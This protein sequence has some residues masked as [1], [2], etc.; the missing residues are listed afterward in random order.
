MSAIDDL[1]EDKENPE[2]ERILAKEASSALAA[3]KDEESIL[4]ERNHNIQIPTIV[5]NDKVQQIEVN[6]HPLKERVHFEKTK[7]SKKR[8]RHMGSNE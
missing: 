2:L 8:Y 6:L 4:T 5:L 3:R 7:E 1:L